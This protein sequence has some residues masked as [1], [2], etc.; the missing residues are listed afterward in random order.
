MT[1]QLPAMRQCYGNANMDM[2]ILLPSL[3]GQSATLAALNALQRAAQPSPGK[4]ILF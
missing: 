3:I 1:T 2:N 4:S